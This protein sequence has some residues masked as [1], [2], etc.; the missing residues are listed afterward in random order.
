VTNMKYMFLNCKSLRKINMENFNSQN[1][2]DMNWMFN[3]CHSLKKSDI[4]TKDNIILKYFDKQR[5]YMFN[6]TH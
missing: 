1:V 4:E 6:K 5:I 3:G 2:T